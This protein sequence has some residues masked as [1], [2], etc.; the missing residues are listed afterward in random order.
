MSG[1]KGRSILA[2]DDLKQL[3]KL[4][5][6]RLGKGS[7]VINQQDDVSLEG[8]LFQAIS[9]G[10]VS[11]DAEASS[12]LYG[13]SAITPNYRMLKSR[14]RKKV[15]NSVFFLEYLEQDKLKVC[16]KETHD[17]QHLLYLAQR[18]TD[19]GAFKTAAK[20]VEQALVIANSAELVPQIIK[21]LEVQRMLY[22]VL[23]DKRNFPLINEKLR[24][25][26]QLEDLER[27]ADALF[28][29]ARFELKGS[30]SARRSFLTKFPKIIEE[31]KAL[32][33]QSLL[34]KV[35]G[36]YHQ[37]NISWY[38]LNGDYEGL[39]QQLEQTEKLVH[40]GK[41]NIIWVNVKFNNFMK[42]YACLRTSQFEQGLSFAE[43]HLRDYEPYGINWFSFIENYIQLA[44]YTKQYTLAAELLKKVLNNSYFSAL[45]SSRKELWELHRRYMQFV[46]SQACKEHEYGF[47]KQK[48]AELKELSTDKEGANL[49]IIIIQFLE[50]I[51]ADKYELLEVQYER[52]GKY[53]TK[54][55]RGDKAERP[56]T[57][58]RL[59]LLVL[60]GSGN[61]KYVAQKCKP[62]L[63]KLVAAKKTENAFAEYELVPYEHL[64]ELVLHLLQ[65]QKG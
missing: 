8:K 56:R 27:K 55:L 39:Y 26:Y 33:E 3:V 40:E 41:L 45:T 4:V 31:V 17:C 5:S 61:Y 11:S 38:E 20:L 18:L 30:V 14:L 46:F 44:L 23:N 22:L 49:A 28:C 62:L 59:L 24:K 13:D 7:P 51:A 43:E 36:Y 60:K 25:Y 32:W 53:I 48:I 35:Y 42:V 6:S 37:L 63:E 29:D 58:L 12:L 65:R 9:N 1:K 34:S 52:V 54:Y 15:L 64:W 21:A 19:F 57:F 16:F 2:M 10:T 47:L 50:S